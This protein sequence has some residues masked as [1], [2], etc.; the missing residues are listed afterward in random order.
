M[1]TTRNLSTYNIIVAKKVIYCIR[2]RALVSFP[3]TFP[4]NWESE[5][6]C[7]GTIWKQSKKGSF[8]LIL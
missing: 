8:P 1:Y 6:V 5:V 4:G 7:F 3:V 2:D